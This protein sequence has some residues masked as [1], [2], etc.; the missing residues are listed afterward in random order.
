MTELKGLRLGGNVSA[1]KNLRLTSLR[2]FHNLKNLKHLDLSTL[3]VVDNSYQTILELENLER[4]DFT[5]VI[6]KQ[7]RELIRTNHQKLTAGLFMDWDYDNQKIYD[8]KEW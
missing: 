7:I 2:P 1:P 6:P 8:D 3:S 4:F 5:V